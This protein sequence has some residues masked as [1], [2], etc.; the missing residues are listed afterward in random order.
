MALVL[1]SKVMCTLLQESLGTRL[2]MTIGTNVH[3]HALYI[4]TLY[5]WQSPQSCTGWPLAVLGWGACVSVSIP[6]WDH[7]M[8]PGRIGEIAAIQCN[9]SNL[10]TLGTVSLLVRCPNFRGCTRIGCW[11]QPKCHTHYDCDLFIEM[12]WLASP[13]RTMCE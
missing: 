8:D 10:D 12:T 13:V 2:Q 9:L 11:G 3:V 5:T 7:R 1:S 4:W 6:C